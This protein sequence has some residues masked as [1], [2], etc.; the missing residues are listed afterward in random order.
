MLPAQGRPAAWPRSLVRGQTKAGGPGILSYLNHQYKVRGSRCQSSLQGRQLSSVQGVAS[1]TLGKAKQGQDS[2]SYFQPIF[3]CSQQI[4][5]YPEAGKRMSLV[6]SLEK[7]MAPD[8]PLPAVSDSC[9]HSEEWWVLRRGPQCGGSPS[10][11]QQQ[12]LV[13]FPP[14]GRVMSYRRV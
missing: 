7:A 13:S 2:I 14:A 5:T 11:Q 9:F 6:V 3:F 1:C 4:Y 8:G 10:F 12:M